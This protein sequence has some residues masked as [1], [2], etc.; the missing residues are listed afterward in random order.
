MTSAKVEPR[1]E[2]T[3][4]GG[5]ANTRTSLRDGFARLE[6]FWPGDSMDRA[7]DATSSEHPLVG[8]VD[9]RVNIESR[10]IALNDAYSI[11]CSP[12]LKAD[13]AAQQDVVVLCRVT[14]VGRPQ[15]V[16]DSIA[17]EAGWLREFICGSDRLAQV[18]FE[19][20]PQGL[21]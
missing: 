3:L 5:A 11:H 1:C 19:I 9:D 21:F 8:S 7:V 16:H 17:L 2:T 12:P 20:C 18:G 6:E 4:T 10:E 13:A 15:S 14:G